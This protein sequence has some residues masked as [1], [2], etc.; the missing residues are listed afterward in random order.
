MAEDMKKYSNMAEFAAELNLAR[1]TVSYILNDKWKERNISPETVK[2]V[3]EY[4]RKVNFVPNFFGRAIKG[5][6]HSDA[7]VLLPSNAYW[8]HREAFFRLLAHLD[9]CGLKYMVLPVSAGAG[10][11]PVLEQLLAYNVERVVMIASPLIRKKEDV[12]RWKN[13]I[14]ATSGIKW[15]LYDCPDDDLSGGIFECS[16]AGYVGPDRAAA[17]HSVFAYV[18]NRGYDKLLYYGFSADN[19][20]NGE[21]KTEPVF[22]GGSLPGTGEPDAGERIADAL[23]AR[24]RQKKTPCAV[25]INDDLLTISVI[26][27]LLARGFR[28]PEDFAFVSW[29]GLKVSRYF[30]KQLTTLEIPHEKMLVSALDFLSGRSGLPRL[31]FAP[32]IREGETLPVIERQA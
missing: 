32:E 2:R 12:E 21:I 13:G 18:K 8:H 3:K 10:A 19:F 9:G 16:N 27:A 7:A 1:S 31:R 22:A 26:S 25:F 23:A 6:I 17:L 4:A 30:H 24:D 20:R 15:L 28:V 14:A 29:D 5:K 11:V